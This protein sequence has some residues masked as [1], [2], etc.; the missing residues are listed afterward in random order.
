MSR[1]PEKAAAINK[2][3]GGPSASP[4]KS[5]SSGSSTNR[6]KPGEAAVRTDP[7]AAQK[8]RRPLSRVATENAAH[9]PQRHPSLTRSSTDPLLPANLKREGSDAP[10]LSSIPLQQKDSKTSSSRNSLSQFERFSRR[11][12]DLDAMAK[13]NEAK[14]KKKAHIEQELEKAIGTLR[15]PNRGAALKDVADSADSRRQLSTTRSSTKPGAPVTRKPGGGSNILVG[16]TPKRGRKTKDIILQATPNHNR[17]S[18]TL[19]SLPSAAAAAARNMD[20]DEDADASLPFASDPVIPSSAVRPGPV[21]VIAPASYSTIPSSVVKNASSSSAS[22]RRSGGGVEETP[23]RG[24]AGKTVHWFLPSGSADRGPEA[25]GGI[26][27]TPEA[28]AGGMSRLGDRLKASVSGKSGGDGLLKV[29]PPPPAFRMPGAPVSRRGANLAGEEESEGSEDEYRGVAALMRTPTKAGRGQVL[30]TPVK[31]AVAVG[32]TPVKGAVGEREGGRES[33]GKE[34]E[35][36]GGGMERIE[37]EDGA[38]ESIYNVLGWD[39]VD[40]LAF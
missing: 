39:D 24:P 5:S 37:E 3:L 15:K 19:S 1:L 20:E 17:F 2:R 12:I 32:E 7:R 11:T 16:A 9:H 21:D 30:E 26:A 10:S 6:S 40:E 36:A 29:P 22:A 14:L 34:K 33:K 13:S 35:V 25:S 38:E 23:S 8:K 31:R 18:S 4:A 28:K 27:A